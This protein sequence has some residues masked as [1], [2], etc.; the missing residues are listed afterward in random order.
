MRTFFLGIAPPVLVLLSG[1]C[2]WVLFSMGHCER[3]CIPEPHAIVIRVTGGILVLMLVGVAGLVVTALLARGRQE[4]LAK[5]S[6]W[7]V[8]V[9]LSLFV[10]WALY[11]ISASVSATT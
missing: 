5:L 10:A 4:R 7:L 9:G 1:W 11:A 8:S 2:L 6:G 3:A